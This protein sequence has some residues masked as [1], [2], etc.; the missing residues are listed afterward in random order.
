MTCNAMCA[1][2]PPQDAQINTQKGPAGGKQ[3]CPRAQGPKHIIVLSPV[4]IQGSFSAFN[5]K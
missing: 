2:R 4:A 1:A 5:R 3:A